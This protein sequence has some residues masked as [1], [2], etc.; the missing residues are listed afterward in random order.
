MEHWVLLP[1]RVLEKVITISILTGKDYS[2]TAVPILHAVGV[3]CLLLK[4]FK[5]G[6]QQADISYCA[7]VQ[8]NIT[9]VTEEGKI[10]LTNLEASDTEEA[11]SSGVEH[12]EQINSD[13]HTINK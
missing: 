10:L 3:C 8:N 9:T 4:S 12:F 11:V 5:L 7:F 1:V 6:Y 13:W 2:R